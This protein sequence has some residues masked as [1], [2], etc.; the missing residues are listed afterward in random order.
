MDGLAAE[1]RGGAVGTR[2]GTVCGDLDDALVS[3]DC[4]VAE[5]KV[6]VRAPRIVRCLLLLSKRRNQRQSAA[7]GGT[8]T[9]SDAL[10]EALR[11][12]LRDALGRPQRTCSSLSFE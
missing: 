1:V 4:E 6:M 3:R 12:A 2:G 5:P 7:L 10:R 9:H 11:E 8:Q